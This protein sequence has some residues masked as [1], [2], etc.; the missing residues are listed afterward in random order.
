MKVIGVAHLIES[1]DLA[2]TSQGELHKIPNTNWHP[3]RVGYGQRNPNKY[4]KFSS[5]GMIGPF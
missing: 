2:S 4:L 3:G 5:Y 1:C